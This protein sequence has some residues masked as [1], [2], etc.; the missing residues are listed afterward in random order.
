MLIG[1]KKKKTG[2]KKKETRKIIFDKKILEKDF[3]NA[4]KK[5]LD[6]EILWLE[7]KSFKNPLDIERAKELKKRILK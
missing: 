1:M 7:S 3:E 5:A 6:F 2:N 4:L